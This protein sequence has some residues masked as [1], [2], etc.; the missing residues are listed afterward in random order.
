MT[1]TIVALTGVYD[2]DGT[3]VGE[4]R[5][6]F[7]AR[8]GRAHCALCDITHGAVRE[9]SA[10]RDCRDGL[11]VPFA[12]V[13][14]DEQTIEVA[15]ATAGVYPAVVATLDD[16]STVR[17]LDGAALAGAAAA[18]DRSAALVAAVEAAA[19]ARGLV[20]SAGSLRDG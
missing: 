4:L 15:A 18:P 5:Y 9:R 2:A 13:H 14:R 1:S 7:G 16:G 8:L 19:S 12:T 10:W 3:I 20:W 6:W 17:L 11:T